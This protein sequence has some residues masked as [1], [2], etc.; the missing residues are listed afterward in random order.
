MRS[1]RQVVRPA[2]L[3]RSGYYRNTIQIRC[4]AALRVPKTVLRR[5]DRDQPNSAVLNVSENYRGNSPRPKLMPPDLNG[6]L[7]AIAPCDLAL[8]DQL[9]CCAIVES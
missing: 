2:R 6:A 9:K 8:H 5:P 1:A 3:S 4:P 7:S